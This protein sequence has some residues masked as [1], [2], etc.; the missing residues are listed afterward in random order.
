[1][2]AFVFLHQSNLPVAPVRVPFRARSLAALL[3]ASLFGAHAQAQEVVLETIRVEVAPVDGPDR[4]AP[5][6]AYQV[7]RESL[8]LFDAPGSPNPLT[9]VAELPGVKI[10]AV[11]AYGLN[12]LQGGQKG[13]RVRGEVSTH[14]VMGTVEGLALGGPGPGPGHLFLFDK[15]NIAAVTLAQGAVSADAGGLFTSHGA[16]DTRLLYPRDHARREISFGLG[17][18]GFQRYFAR[19]DTGLLETGAALFLSASKT[20]ADKWRGDGDAPKGRDNMALGVKQALGKLSMKFF[21]AHNDQVQHAYRALTY[22]EARHDNN[23]DYGRDSSKNDYYDFNRQDFRNQS[24]VGEVSHDFSDQTRLSF[25]PFW[26]KE[27]GHYLF[28]A[29]SNN[30][31]TKMLIDHDSYGATAELSTVLA[32]TRVRLGYAWTSVEPPGP[33]INQK[34]YRVIDGRLAFAQWAKLSRVRERHEFESYYLTGLRQFDRLTL[35]GG[36]RY[37]KERLP[38][39]DAYTA[40]AATAGGSWDVSPRE[41]AK[42]ATKND[43]LSVKARGFDH[44]LPQIGMAYDLTSAA[45]VYANLGRNIGMPALNVFMQ[46][47]KVGVTTVQQYWDAIRPELSTNLDVGARLHL[48]DI[49]LDPTLY[50]SR[51]RNKGVN[52]Y[53]DVSQSIWS[54]NVGETA[55]RGVLLAAAW[56]PS[57][58][59]RVFGNAS[60]TRSWFTR[61]IRGVG[62]LALD[63]RG[64]QLPDVPKFMGNIGMVMKTGGVTLA[65]MAQYVGSRWGTVNYREKIPGYFTLDV[66]ASYG[67][68]LREGHWEAS[69]AL[70]NV[71][72]RRYIGQVNANETTISSGAIYYPGAPRTLAAKLAYTF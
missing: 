47:T 71:F 6:T 15:E 23:K 29:A 66:T 40:G 30:M 45:S 3:A 28:A 2:N 67:R 36:V 54:Q 7:G 63:V 69:L 5:R 14:G 43:T 9:A 10:A 60:Y 49:T 72:D 24:L 18:E 51:T 22:D 25:K 13:I 59:L 64:N 46:A 70:L 42:R 1:M 31:V 55:A 34:S 17:S 12:N 41:A 57:E 33:Q 61:D 50:F 32:D 20:K 16:L 11:D 8:R 26:L 35:Q 27:E 38:G 4:S 37:V 65:P 39:I 56:T 21:Y 58:T 19:V 53:D 52:V 48:G 68:K 62:G 44:W